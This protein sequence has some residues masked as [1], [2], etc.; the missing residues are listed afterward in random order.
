LPFCS[1]ASNTPG[2]CPS[3]TNAF[4][5]TWE[6]A[7]NRYIYFAIA[8]ETAAAVTFQFTLDWP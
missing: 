1:F 2:A 3:N 6:F 4:R 8:R 7:A 5:F